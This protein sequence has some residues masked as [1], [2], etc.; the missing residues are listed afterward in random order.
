LPWL[1][2]WAR[3]E[4]PP[5]WLCAD[6]GAP[7]CACVEGEVVGLA[8]ALAGEECVAAFAR[9]EA[10]TDALER[11]AEAWRAGCAPVAP[12]AP[13]ATVAVPLWALERTLAL[14]LAREPEL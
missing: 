4:L 10:C 3:T 8:T 9:A 1:R 13:V 6:T 2:L 11:A 12:A 5:A 7:A 14:E